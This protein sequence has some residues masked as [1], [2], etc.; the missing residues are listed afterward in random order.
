MK[1]LQ[2]LATVL[3]AALILTWAG[4]AAWAYW[5]LDPGVPARTLAAPE[6]RFLDLDG[7]H[8]RYRS[9]GAPGPGRPELLLI[10]GFGNS[11]QSFRALA[12]R[13]AECCQVIAIDMPGYGLSDK[14]AK[15]DYHNGPQAEVMVKA[16]R[17]LGLRGVVYVGHSLGGAVALQ[18]VVKDPQARGLV[19]LN[20][21]I[22]TTGVPKVVQLNLPPLP[23]M[24]AKLFANREFRASFLRRSYV[25]PDIV[26]PQV[27]DDVMLGTR[28]GDYA[29][30]V[31]SLMA[32]YAEGEELALAPRVKVPT[33]IPWG[34][35]DRNKPL[36]EATALRDLLADSTLVHFPAAGHY[37]HEEATEGV[38]RAIVQWLA[39]T[40]PGGV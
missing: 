21:G 26:T 33:L 15:F 11:L 6:D 37:V 36:S 27:V 5:P 22:I 32:Q 19:L 23:R 17:R 13:L 39:A 12:P 25:N 35:Q 24:S 14:P 10:H 2:R 40:Q 20:P 18:A 9:Y 4:L 34:D 28:T 7:L 30:G 31:T 1:T 3:L 8:L 29:T 16:A 38:A